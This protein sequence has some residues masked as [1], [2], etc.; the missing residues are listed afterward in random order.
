MR[1]G[2]E[3]WRTWFVS[4]PSNLLRFPVA[5]DEDGQPPLPAVN[6]IAIEVDAICQATW[7]VE[8][9]W[10]A[11]VLAPSTQPPVLLVH[12]WTGNAKTFESFY[13]FAIT[14]GY[15][16]RIANSLGGGVK[17]WDESAGLL[18]TEI[19]KT[20]AKYSAEKVHIFAHSRGGLFARYLLRTDPYV[21]SQVDT[22][23]TISTPHHGTDQAE[24][25]SLFNC[26]RSDWLDC[27]HAAGL[28]SEDG[29]KE[30]NYHGCTIASF[31]LSPAFVISSDY[32]AV[33]NQNSLSEAL[34]DEFV[35]HGFSLSPSAEVQT[36]LTDFEWRISGEQPYLIRRNFFQDLDVYSAVA[37][38]S[39]DDEV[40]YGIDTRWFGCKP[41]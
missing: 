11:I 39:P 12:G 24:S 4:F 23:V 38:A 34:L 22:V 15:N 6:E 20:L 37:G 19:Q 28:I 14:A 8:V 32:M 10:G 40:N 17:D 9:D 36:Y 13:D 18:A 29:M 31:L 3:K 27:L 35:Q 21:A 26:W 7:A 30:F 5:A 1:G 16:M 2:N 41:N 33:L 25:A